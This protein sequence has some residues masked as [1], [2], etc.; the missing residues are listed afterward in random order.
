MAHSSWFLCRIIPSYIIIKPRRTYT[1]SELT[2]TGDRRGVTRF[3][4]LLL[5]M[6]MRPRSVSM[7][8]KYTPPPPMPWPFGD[9]RA[10]RQQRCKGGL[11]RVVW[12]V[13]G[14]L[15]AR[16]CCAC[17]IFPLATSKR[18]PFKT[19]SCYPAVKPRPWVFPRAIRASPAT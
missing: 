18:V 8:P 9:V 4:K 10:V 12:H 13:T 15:H 6:L 5:N 2:R 19:L 11:S 1:N 3:L 14:W 7:S 17:I 16:A